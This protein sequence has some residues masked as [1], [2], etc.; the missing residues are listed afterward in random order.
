MDG[1]MLISVGPDSVD[2]YSALVGCIVRVQGQPQP[3]VSIPNG[4]RLGCCGRRFAVEHVGRQTL[5]TSGNCCIHPFMA[6]GI[7]DRTVILPTAKAQ[8]LV[9]IGNV[10][11]VVG[12]NIYKRVEPKYKKLFHEKRG[13]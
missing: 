3:A 13:T 11:P 10:C 6:G 2:S 7:L 9:H 8:S 12:C 4:S 1:V 5:V